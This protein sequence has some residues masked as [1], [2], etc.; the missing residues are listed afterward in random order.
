MATITISRCKIEHELL[1]PVCI[2]TGVPTA[3]THPH[4]FRWVPEWI[5]FAVIA[6]V[7]AYIFVRLLFAIVGMNV[8]IFLAVFAFVP[9]L[10]VALSLM[11]LKPISC[12]VPIVRSKRFY[13]I[14]R[15]TTG[16]VWVL[17]CV[18]LIIN[19]YTNSDAMNGYK[20]G[21]DY[22]LWTCRAGLGLLMIG[23]IVGHTI[24]RTSIRV[25]EI[26][27]AGMTLVNVHANFA[28]MMD[29]ERKLEAQREAARYAAY[30][31]WRREQDAA[32]F[33]GWGSGHPLA[34]R[35]PDG[36]AQPVPADP[37]A[38]N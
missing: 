35:V 19:G 22:G 36:D 21:P 37:N 13:W 24:N 17:L 10:I 3:N 12:D 32:E 4:T 7:G 30:T 27:D 23:W 33:A 2:L 5:K 9:T 25:V 16:V 11:K 18:V 6:G 20:H 15:K 29:V 28:F 26:D 8:P 14:V 38:S 34:R 1:P 31:A